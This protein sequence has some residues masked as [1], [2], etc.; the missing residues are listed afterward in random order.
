MPYSR[1][2]IPE[3]RRFEIT[4]EGEV[5]ADEIVQNYMEMIHSDDWGEDV[6]RLV[7]VKSGADLSEL[8]I[9]LFQTRFVEILEETAAISGPPK[10]QAWV[11]ENDVTMPIVKT[12][13]LMPEALELDRFKVF[14]T[15][16]EALAWLE[17]AS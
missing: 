11:I 9:E 1:H 15:R 17:K 3:A 7:T 10:K 13:E 5:P 16:E 12:W 6:V 14:Q 4:F 2:F 8:T